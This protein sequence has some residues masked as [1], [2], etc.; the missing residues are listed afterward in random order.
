MAIVWTSSFFA[1]LIYIGFTLNIFAGLTVIGLI[2]L[3]RKKRSR[4]RLCVG[5]PLPP[6]IVLA[7]ATWVTIWSVQ[8]QPLS[9]LAGLTTV[10]IGYVAYRISIRAGSG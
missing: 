2:Q 8:S 5:Y 6:V 10:G 9:A 7:F 3:R 4:Y 1:L